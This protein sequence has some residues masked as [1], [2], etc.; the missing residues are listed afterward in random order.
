MDEFEELRAG[1]ALLKKDARGHNL[2]TDTL[3]L[4][5]FARLKRGECCIDLGCGSGALCVLLSQRAKDSRFTAI[6][7]QPEAAEIARENFAA[8]GLGERSIVITGDFRDYKKLLPVGGAD[9]VVSNPPYFSEKSGAR[10]GTERRELQ[11]RETGCTLNDVIAAAAW[12]LR[13][14]G[15]LFLVYRPERLSELLC[16]MTT[17]RVE[18]KRL[19]LTHRAIDAPPSL[20]LVEGRRGGKAG[21]AIEPPLILTD[22]KIGGTKEEEEQ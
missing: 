12:A 19:R 3:L 5:D 8:N 6:E 9:A 16:A 1:G 17:A 21:L 18:P 15:A 2:T 14:G 13:N 22:G 20:V 10:A 11:R 7:I 4:A